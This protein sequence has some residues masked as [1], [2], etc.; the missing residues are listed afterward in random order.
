ML[1]VDLHPGETRAGGEPLRFGA[2]VRTVVARRVEDV[3]EALRAVETATA[4][5]LWA[6]G[7]VTYDAAPAFD[8]AFVVP[9][10]PRGEDDLPL[11]WF[12][13]HEA[14]LAGVPAP[15]APA[16]VLGPWRATT[17]PAAYEAAF[18]EVQAAIRR[19]D[20]YQTNLTV[21]LAAAWD[22]GADDLARYE[23]LLAAQGAAFG[24]YLEV[25]RHHVLSVSPELF[26]ARHGDVVTTRPMK[27]TAR[28]GRSAAEDAERLAGLRASV[29]DRAE[30][31]MITDLLRNDLGRVARPGT[32]D[33][34][35]LLVAERYPTVWQLT[36]TV[37]AEV[38]PGT[39]LADLFGALFPC[40]SITGAPKITTM[41]IIATLEPSARG[42]YCGA[43]GV[44]A[45]GGD[46]TFAVAIRTVV[47][48]TVA[49]TAT[50]GVGSGVT[51]DSSAAGEHDELLAKSAVL[52]APPRP[53]FD[54]LETLRLEDGAC[55]LLDAH[56]DRLAA[57]AAFF[58][59]PDPV[60]AA[61]AALAAVAAAHPTGRWRVRLTVAEDGG[62][63]TEVVDLPR[64]PTG[65]LTLVLAADPVDENDPFLA[66]KTT[67]RS[68]YEPHLQRARSLGAD[69]ALLWNTRGEITETTT[70][71][72]LVGSS[73]EWVTPPLDCGL[74]PG[75]Q[76]QLALDEGPVGERVLTV[77]ELQAALD[78]GAQLWF[79]NSVRG[80]RR[81][82]L[83]R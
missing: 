2:P 23:R 7:F 52:T 29:K 61:R 71:N 22:D 42:L 20:T 3:V 49:R 27:G 12:G 56:V 15:A 30:N 21:R 78:S 63:R 41:S 43:V 10:G 35:A 8:P 48:D 24:A 65:S 82:T 57:S 66:H 70:G 75:V 37:T 77:D 55:W 59:R 11:V 44:V 45:P 17:G 60:P 38:P 68:V 79:L 9:G 34:P 69:D 54:L 31:V 36:S 1:R 76:R 26:F 74:L 73:E 40:G 51:V 67:R 46:A 5:G 16:T 19:G 18:D 80:W 33:V 39:G 72:V 81:A 50:Y 58:E 47:A 14:P 28:R 53:A 64:D 32:V 13:L 25:G 62:A 4:D 83:L 6:V